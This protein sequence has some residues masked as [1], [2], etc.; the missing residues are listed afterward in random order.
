[1][2]GVLSGCHDMGNEIAEVLRFN[3]P[4][5]SEASM[6][7]FHRDAEKRRLGITLIS[8]AEFGGESPYLKVYREAVTDLDSMVRAA[9]VR[10]LGMHGNGEDALLAIPL[11]VDEHQ[12]VRWEAAKALQRL[13]HRDAIRALLV[14]VN[15]DEDADVRAAAATALGQY[16]ELRVADALILSLSD[17]SLIVNCEA[18]KS[19]KTLTGENFGIN[20]DDWLE[21]YRD[22]PNVFAHQQVYTYPTYQREYTFIEKVTPFGRQSFESPGVPAG[23]ERDASTENT[24]PDNPSQDG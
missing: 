2:M 11:T 5:P 9:S 18:R 4:T 3:E 20:Q 17:Q 1:M 13:H 14:A 24:H 15:N 22:N 19:L 6:W 21:W 7:M 10:A 12:I 23:A 16:A 8:N